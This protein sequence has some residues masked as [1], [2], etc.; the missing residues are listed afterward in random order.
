M[1]AD[2]PTYKSIRMKKT[3][4]T[5]LLLLLIGPLSAEITYGVRAGGAYSS[6][7]QRRDDLLKSGGRFGYSIAGLADIRL[8]HR[9]S[10]R[11]ELVFTNQGGSYYTRYG[12]PDAVQHKCNYFSVQVPVNVMYTFTYEGVKFGAGGGPCIDV[13]LWGHTKTDG[14]RR[15]MD[16]GTRPGDDLK[17]FDLGVNVGI[18]IEYSR[19]FFAINAFCGV[20]NRSPL[21]KEG[22]PS[23]YQNNVTF[24]LGYMFRR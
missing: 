20:L 21:K 9:L 23:V 2:K 3:I 13:P 8:Y 24:S 7:L 6:L 5:L 1:R 22:E 10:L 17:A 18:N 14:H 15:L 16:F 4:L 19:F 11:P 12:F